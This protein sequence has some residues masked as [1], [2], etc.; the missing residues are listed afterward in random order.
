MPMNTDIAI[1]T[2]TTMSAVC[3]P[4]MTRESTS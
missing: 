4:Q 3:A 2:T 1:A